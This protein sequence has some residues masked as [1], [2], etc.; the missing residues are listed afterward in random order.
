MT[1]SWRTIL[2]RPPSLPA[3]PKARSQLAA[4]PSVASS[5]ARRG[6][7]GKSRI[8]PPLPLVDLRQIDGPWEPKED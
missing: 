5:A 4:R 3:A 1:S 2:S 8:L 6:E 7:G